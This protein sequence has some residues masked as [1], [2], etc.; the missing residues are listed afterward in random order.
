M[1]K[2]ETSFIVLRFEHDHLR[3]VVNAESLTP[4][5]VG[6]HFRNAKAVV[7]EDLT[8]HATTRGSGSTKEVMTL[9]D[10]ERFFSLCQEL[11]DEG[12]KTI[13][14]VV[15]Q[16]TVT[17]EKAKIDDGV[18]A[19]FNGMPRA[20]EAAARERLEEQLQ[21]RDSHDA[22][23]IQRARRRLSKVADIFRRR[24]SANDS[25]GQVSKDTACPGRANGL[26]SKQHLHGRLPRTEPPNISS[27]PF[28]QETDEID[29]QDT[30]PEMKRM[31]DAVRQGTVTAA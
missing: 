2:S 30:P 1:A 27:A 15:M 19:I 14:Y 21:R 6:E 23:R 24:S 25:K 31:D 7:R 17:K 3:D 9:V 4:L 10:N 29:R 22:D 16:M 18:N 12:N 11:D 8:N 28:A 26:L 5:A 13:N 20:D